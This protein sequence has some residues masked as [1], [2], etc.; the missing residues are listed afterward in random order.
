VM[1]NGFDWNKWAFDA[2]MSSTFARAKEGSES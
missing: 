2:Q 1:P